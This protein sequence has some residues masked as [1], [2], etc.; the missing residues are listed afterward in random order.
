MTALPDER[1]DWFVTACGRRVFVLDPRPEDI[2]IQDIAHALSHICRF[3]G[4][5]LQFYSVAQ[6]SVL[7]SRLVP[8]EL[9]FAALMHDA[10]EA[11]VGD[12]IRPIKRELGEVYKR[13]E[14][15]WEIAIAVRFG[16][17]LSPDDERAIKLADVIALVTERRDIGSPDWRSWGWKEDE[18]GI[19]PCAV[20]IKPQSA[21]LARELFMQRF[22]E[23]VGARS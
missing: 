11:Y 15:K 17:D 8:R 9:A 19:E 22:D 5:A 3:G 2:A 7:V 21:E 16:F 10:A 6:H 4:H 13:I 14:M 23:L 18:L 12:V 1:G 20:V